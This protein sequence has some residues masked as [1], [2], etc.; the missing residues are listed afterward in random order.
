MTAGAIAPRRG[1]SAA[2]DYLRCLSLANLHVVNVWLEVS[3]RGFDFF[4]AS[5]PT[6]TMI[7]AAVTLVLLLSL[8]FWGT[9]Q[10]WRLLPPRL[11][12]P[13]AII[14]ITVSVLI[15]LDILH[16]SVLAGAMDRAIA[17]FGRTTVQGAVGLVAAGL[18]VW[19]AVRTRAAIRVYGLALSLA[20]P[21]APILLG[22]AVWVQWQRPAGPHYAGTHAVD[23]RQQAPTRMVVMIFDEWDQRL[24][25]EERPD[26]IALPA[27]D[28]IVGQ[29]FH[30]SRVAGGGYLGVGSSIKS[31]LTGQRLKTVE[32]RSLGVRLDGE[33][34]EVVDPAAAWIESPTIFSELAGRGWSTSIVGWYIPYCRLLGQYLRA[35]AWQPGGSVYGRREFLFDL[36]YAQSLR[37]LAMRQA[38]RLPLSRTLGLESSIDE[39]RQL[40]REELSRIR[41]DVAAASDSADFLYVHWPVPHPFGVDDGSAAARERR[42]NY[43]DN[44][45][46][47]DGLLS[48]FQERLTR[49]GRWDAVT[50]VLTADHSLRSRYWRG[51]GAWTDEEQRATGGRQ[52]PYVPFVVKFAG[53]HAPLA[54]DHPFTIALLYDVV[55]AIA[56]GTVAS[57]ADLAK[58]LDAHR[59][60]HPTEVGPRRGAAVNSGT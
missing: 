9:V 59:G 60:K 4:R 8:V 29:S 49:E 26:R 43:L 30:A 28:R 14:G 35:C 31:I 42:P 33:R 37:T 11:S 23:T 47:A 39:R 10:A 7:V 32:P 50:L 48:E 6:A 56:D 27:L 1:G 54:Y 53:H 25:I 12:R 3:N 40:L 17:L 5:R 38:E 13:A 41:A 20:L 57:P 46:V 19:L 34:R 16:R 21:L 24:A 55:L 58:W 51:L 2:R 52:S 18:L 45:V 15:P 44:L 36:S 22:Q